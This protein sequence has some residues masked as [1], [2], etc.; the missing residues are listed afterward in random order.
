MKSTVK[1]DAYVVKKETSKHTTD[2]FTMNRRMA[3]FALAAAM[4]AAQAPLQA[5]TELWGEDGSA[6]TPDSPLPDFSFA[7]YHQGGKELPR[8]AAD[9]SVADFG[10]V[11]DGETDSTAAFLRAI[12]ES[13]GKVIGIPK[14]TYLLNDRLELAEAHTVL[15]GEGSEDTILF[16]QRGLQEIEPA[17]TVTGSGF[18]TNQWSWS[19]G[20]ITVGSRRGGSGASAAVTEAA[21]RGGT[22]LVVEDASRF[23]AGTMCVIRVDDDSE[24]SLISYVYRGRPGD[25][26][27]MS[28]GNF[29]LTQ[30]VTVAKV[31]GR[32]VTIHQPLRFDL[33]P[34]WS[35]RL[36]LITHP[37]QE[38]GIGGF[39]IRF[40]E[41]PYR[42]HW[43][44]DG[45]N[46]FALYGVNNWARDIRIENC[47]S[48][49]FITGTWCSV[50]GLT[51]ESSRQAHASG[52]TGHHGITL[53]GWECLLRDFKIETKF[54]HDITVSS[55]SVGNVFS[56]GSGVDLAMDHHRRAPYENLFTQIH[57]GE[58]TRV[59][60]SGGTK[61]LGLHSASGGTFWNLDSRKRFALPD[62]NFGP[63]GLIFAGLNTEPVRRNDLVEGWHYERFRPGEIQPSNLHEA[64]RARRLGAAGYPASGGEETFH[65]WSNPEGQ[66]IE[67]LFLGVTADTVRLRTREGQVH[68][69][70][71]ERLS[72]ESQALARRL[73]E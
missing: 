24:Q 17:E 44:E 28:D 70:P 31:E 34:G 54:F 19:G 11:G 69:Y 22:E 2:I 68:D 72:D 9:V 15:I 64:Q 40:P 12:A 13:P 29:S 30:A 66:V 55:G 26:S 63:P 1:S 18:A 62:E 20:I 35:P 60:A 21:V 43:M 61:G 23:Q 33:R 45:M 48:G 25:I 73:A 37:S 59:W 39:T 47:D 10:A 38:M 52:N 46:G 27:R 5:Q 51:L 53:T 36:A 7:G 58:A 49:A 57:V 6:W 14:G 42:G 71:L 16:F 56:R 4:A 50:E 8:P 32:T 41:R 67:A 3:F 65:R